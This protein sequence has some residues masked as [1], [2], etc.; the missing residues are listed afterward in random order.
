MCVGVGTS[1]RSCVLQWAEIIREPVGEDIVGEHRR[2][3]RRRG[4]EGLVG[5]PGTP[6]CPWDL[7][8]ANARAVS[9]GVGTSQR[10]CVLQWAEI[11]R[12]PAGFEPTLHNVHGQT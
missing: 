2:R 8:G 4:R 3:E 11:I 5:G 12:E 10:S 1:Q 9:V 7:T 6:A